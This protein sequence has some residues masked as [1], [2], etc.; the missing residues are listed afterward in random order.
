MR[1]G[2]CG[3]AL[4]ANPGFAAGGRIPTR[5]T[6]VLSWRP[7][8]RLR[9]LTDGIGDQFPGVRA[10]RFQT[11]RPN[12]GGQ[13]AVQRESRPGVCR[14]RRAGQRRRRGPGSRGS[15]RHRAEARAEH[16]GCG[17]L[18]VRVLRRAARRRLASRTRWTSRS[19]CRA[20]SSSRFRRRSR[21]SA[22]AA[23]RRTTSRT[24]SRRRW[25][26]TW[27]ARTSPA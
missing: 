25:R 12:A 13:H 1:A 26:C 2:T 8:T 23:S 22:C 19:R 20:C 9:A 3:R 10:R 24:T 27:M 5:K 15:D 17:H 16:A 4:S 11:R 21:C 14:R 6:Q 18:R 7:L